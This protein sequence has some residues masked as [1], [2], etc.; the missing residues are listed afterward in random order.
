[1]CF[2][3]RRVRF[4]IPRR[5]AFS[6]RE[7]HYRLSWKMAALL[8]DWTRKKCALLSDSCGLNTQNP[9]PFA[10]WQCM[11]LMWCPSDKCGNGVV[12]FQVVGWVSWPRTEV[13]ASQHQ[14][15]SSVSS[16]YS[17]G[18]TDVYHWSSCS[19]HGTS[20]IDRKRLVCR[21]TRSRR[22]QE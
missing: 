13:A 19:W 12:T 2:V 22:V 9:W 20:H 7:I 17:F 10:Y 11:I 18:R 21:G 16:T 4:A 3:V 8:N 6:V 5:Q 1:M 15:P 14:T